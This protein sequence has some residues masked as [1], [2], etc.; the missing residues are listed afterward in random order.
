MAA[1]LNFGGASKQI[2]IEKS[3]KRGTWNPDSWRNYP[4]KQQPIY[5][6]DN[7]VRAAHRQLS[8]LTPLCHPTEIIR[9]R[10]QLLEVHQGKRFFIIGG[11]CAERF[12]DC[13]SDM[14]EAKV[15]TILQMSLI[16]HQRTNLPLVRGMRI[17]GQYGKPRSSPYENL[18]NGDVIPSFK[19]DN[20]NS[21]DHS[22]RKPDPNR[23][24][25]GYFHSAAT[26]NYMR[27][28]AKTNFSDLRESKNWQ[29]S[30]D[31]VSSMSRKNKGIVSNLLDNLQQHGEDSNSNKNSN[32]ED[33]G[34]IFTAHE[35][36]I[37]EYESALT[38]N[39]KGKWYNTSAHFVWIG[40]R[41]RQLDHAHVE[42]FRGIENPIGIK[43]GPSSDPNEIVEVVKIVNP[44]N[45][46]GKVVLITRL[47]AKQVGELLPRVIRTIQ[48]A[49]LN[50]IWQ[51]DPMHGNTRKTEAGIKTRSFNV[52]LDEITQT[53]QIHSECGS[54]LHGVHFELTG[55]NVTECTGGP[56]NLQDE[57]LG[58]NYTSYC[59]PRLN[60]QQS[61][62][63]A[64]KLGELL[65]QDIASRSTSVSTEEEEVP[66]IQSKIFDY[67]NFDQLSPFERGF[68]LFNGWSW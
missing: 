22:D 40:D 37:L 12:L 64:F 56:Q 19:G 24:V 16:L 66:Q 1:E 29:S 9:L 5:E 51:C 45:I 3:K 7:K 63:M 68:V 55:E 67:F 50:I 11:D 21:I 42:Y 20:V 38:R 6:D 25:T 65:Q 33:E 13:N 39:Y 60:Y 28:L 54:I 59:D 34:D 17:A 49:D 41:T 8:S 23:L 57:D 26:L 47:S 61:M 44:D 52:I 48:A 32:L 36:L 30:D 10:K 14:I 43:V 15:K 4:I 62:E 18:P 53:L 2:L 46:P 27:A 58:L 31:V 35:A